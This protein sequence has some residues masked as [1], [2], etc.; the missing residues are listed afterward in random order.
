MEIEKIISRIK[1]HEKADSIGMIASH[2]GI[3]RGFS[4]KGGDIKAVNVK[5]DTESL[6]RVIAHIKTMPGIVE[7]L[8]EVNE[9]YLK[10][11][12]ELMFVAVGGDIRENVFDALIEAVNR[13]KKQAVSKEE[14]FIS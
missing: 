13:I 9:G 14:I 5:Y 11:G 3:V 10:V 8:V 7:V 6:N 2:L 1:N 12:D 4:R